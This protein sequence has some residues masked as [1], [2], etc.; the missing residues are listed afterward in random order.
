M[1]LL[2]GFVPFLLLVVHAHP[3]Q[4]RLRDTPLLS[5]PDGNNYLNAKLPATIFEN[6]GTY[7]PRYTVDSALPDAVPAGCKVSLVNSLERH[8]ARYQTSGS[9]STA[10]AT[11]VKITAA[12]TNV[13]SD[14]LP[15]ELRF[16]KAPRILS[17]TAD[18]VPFGALQAYESGRYTK[19]LYSKLADDSDAFIRTTGT[20]TSDRVIVTAQ[21]WSLGYNGESF[22]DGELTD[23]PSVRAGGKTATHQPDVILSEATGQNNTLDVSSCPSAD[24]YNDESGEDEA[25]AAYGNSTLQ[26]VIG[27]RLEKAFASAGA[28][29]NLTYVDVANLFNLC[30]FSTLGNATTTNG[31]LSIEVSD[32]CGIFKSQEFELYEYYQDVGFY[33]GYGPGSPYSRALAIGYLRELNARLSSSPVVLD[34]PTS[35]NTTLDSSSSTF[36]IPNNATKPSDYRIFFDGSHD[37]QMGP[38]ASAFG[39]FDQSEKLPLGYN[40]QQSFAAQGRDWRF[41][42]IAPLQ[43]KIV[44]EKLECGSSSYVRVRANEAI[45]PAKSSSWCPSSGAEDATRLALGLCPL[46][47]VLKGLQWT[48]SGE[49]WDKCYAPAVTTLST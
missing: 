48:K 34:P 10:N 42:R 13:S 25:F 31:Q 21:Y 40:A 47:S 29:L 7:S 30:A 1:N 6:L 41:S 26:P 11:L 32:Y 15:K 20:P 28:S 36:P 4:L 14:K 27:A 9:L 12:L 18:L 17:G 44:F 5:G 35:L 3:A 33:Y 49:E 38:I 8:G 22:P 2:V 46:E 45:Q 37:D 24:T 23:G 16:L 39:L 43:G 19:E